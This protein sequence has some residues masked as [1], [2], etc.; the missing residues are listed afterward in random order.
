MAYINKNVS[1]MAMPSG[2]NRMGQFPLDMSSVYYDL[3][4]LQAY[5]TSGSI[6]YVGQIVSLVD[7][8]NKKV[9]VYSIQNTD[10]LLKEVGTVPTGDESSVVV[11]AEGKIALKGVADLVF[12][13]ELEDGGKEAVQYQPLMTSAGLVW[14]EPSKTTVEGLA[15]LIEGLNTRV[16]AIEDDYLKAEAIANMATD[17][18]V[19]AAVKVETDRAVAAEEALGERIDGVDG[20]FASYVTT[21]A[22]GTF[23]TE[24]TQA[25]ADAKSGAETTAANALAAARTEISKEIDDD[26]KVA[27]DRA[28]EAYTLAS[29]KVDAEIYATDKAEAK[30][31]RDAIREIAEEAKNTIDAFLESEEID[32]TVNT[33]KEIQEE[34]KELGDAVQLEEQ[35]AAKAD[36]TVV[37]GIE[38]RVKAIEDAPY[39]T[40]AQLDEVDGKF[41]D[42][43]DTDA[44]T[45]LLAGKQDVI[46]E[47]TYDA[48]GSASAAEEAAKSHADSVAA[49]AKSEA[50]EAAASA[51]AGIYATKTSVSDLETALDGRLDAL[52][53][54]NHELYATK[55]ELNAHNT[56]AEA[57][58]ATKEALA[59]VEQTANNA[60]AKVETLE[61]KI[62]EI[63]SVGGEPNVI[64]YVKVNGTILEVEKDAE[65]KSTKTVNVI[66]PTKFSD[67][68]DDSGFDARITAAQNKADKGVTDAATAA[69]AASAAQAKADANA[70]AISAHATAIELLQEQDKTHTSDIAA[71]QQHDRDHTA[72]YEALKGTVSTHGT[73]I[74]DLKGGKADV[75]VTDGLAS[76]ISANENA[77][78][79]LNGTTIPGI[80]DQISNLNSNKA[81]KTALND[82]Y[83]K[84]EI[85]GEVETLEQAIANAITEASYDDSEV[86]GLITDITKNGG[87][88]DTKVN[89]LAEGAVTKN[90]SDIADVAADLALVDAAVKANASAITALKA[91]ENTEGSIAALIKAEADRA[92]GIEADHESRIAEIETFF[93]A[94]ETPDAVIDTLAE[95]VHYIE[96]DTSGA[97]A[98]AADIKANADAIAAI[99]KEDT[100]IL[101][102]AKS[103]TNSEIAKLTNAENGILAQANVYTD[104]EVAKLVKA[105][106]DNLAAAK[107]Y[108]DANLVI[109]KGYSDANL[110]TAKSYA[111]ASIAALPVKDVDNDTIK[112]NEAGNAYVAKVSTDVL[113][114]GSVELIF[115]AGDASG[116]LKTV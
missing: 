49:T 42:Y 98:M 62:E 52:E 27:K 86:R 17:A 38:T 91:D 19:E 41:A 68:T 72:L 39:V 65:G 82:Y 34:L 84:V 76:R 35:F 51:A 25:I 93:D 1:T 79:T 26:V 5:A 22:F 47:N 61:D 109:A 20:K 7:E 40:K 113:V 66:V 111:D 16:K 45:T 24:N 70:T 14:V 69:A 28:D 29:G 8:A 56:A 64:D 30:D 10:G 90:A 106:E 97:S 105:D 43:T 44:L 115:S 18:E 55:E 63:T 6:A 58:Y 92:K 80:N 53:A 101:A 60:A 100:G 33:L 77:I 59:P 21:E 37:E 85:D 57:K 107:A 114:Q 87:A 67:V 12:E 110:A 32:D 3:E 15:T 102:Q 50:I 23:K 13:R 78:K 104:A 116:Y 71:L 4:S 103:Y 108:S 83:T 95:I 99:N 94:V 48:Y 46:P 2:M 73:D 74:A 9:T 81:D 96:T 112:L 54:I 31:D 89:A 11:D 75:T 88:I 36:K